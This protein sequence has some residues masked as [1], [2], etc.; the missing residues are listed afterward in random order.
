MLAADAM[1]AKAT[2]AVVHLKAAVYDVNGKPLD[3]G[4]HSGKTAL[5]AD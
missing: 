1:D 4:K 5:N 3:A 2:S